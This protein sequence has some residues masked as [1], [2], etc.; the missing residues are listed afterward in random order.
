MLYQGMIGVL[1]ACHVGLV[2]ATLKFNS[3]EEGLDLGL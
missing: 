3:S 2:A 1:M